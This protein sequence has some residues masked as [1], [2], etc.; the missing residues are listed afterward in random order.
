MTVEHKDDVLF[1]SA[2]RKDGNLYNFR[3]VKGVLTELFVDTKP[4]PPADFSKYTDVVNE[5]EH[6]AG[7]RQL[8]SRGRQQEAQLRQLEMLRDKQRRIDEGNER[9][10]EQRSRQVE[11]DRIIGDYKRK[12]MDQRDEQD[13]L[14]QRMK[15]QTRDLSWREDGKLRID[16]VH[17]NIKPE[18]RV[19][20][21]ELH[22]KVRP[23]TRI[24]IDTIHWKGKPET[25][26]KLDTDNK[27][28]KK[29]KTYPDSLVWINDKKIKGDFLRKSADSLRRISSEHLLDA[30]DRKQESIRNLHR[31][32][33]IRIKE[34]ADKMR[35]IISDLEKEGIKMDLQKSWFA[36]DKE[37]FIVDGKKMTPELHQKF[38]AKFVK[39]Q[40]GWGYYYGPIQVRG[41]GFFMDYKD[42]VK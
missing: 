12:M 40:D 35:E 16:T 4:I 31:E 22:L 39:S 33:D 25:R 10:R 34:S 7:Y 19:K 6:V 36:L 18:T 13:S 15:R 32:D 11:S 20:M 30:Y 8:R 2:T 9:M 38:L 17:L 42:V 27:I 29:R 3:K 26:L 41:R 28:N 23:E 24:K 37:Q 1:I 21:D 5:I 14:L